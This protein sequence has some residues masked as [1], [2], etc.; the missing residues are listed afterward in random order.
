MGLNGNGEENH[1]RIKIK[2]YSFM[3]W[4]VY[5]T[6]INEMSFD[7]SKWISIKQTHIKNTSRRLST[8]SK[9]KKTFI[10]NYD[11]VGSCLESEQCS[12]F[13]EDRY[14]H[15][16]VFLCLYLKIFIEKDMIRD[17]F[18]ICLIMGICLIVFWTGRQDDKSLKYKIM[19]RCLGRG[20]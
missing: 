4:L 13:V 5:E 17:Y 1:K 2:K 12:R 20:R 8:Q 14:I 9:Y 10:K 6:K 7:S 15:R 18:S 19:K 11:I 3:K 16:K